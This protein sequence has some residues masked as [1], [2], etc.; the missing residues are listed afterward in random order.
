MAKAEK[1]L[2]RTGKA[3]VLVADDH[4]LF[5]SAL[6][7]V[8]AQVFGE[9]EL[10]EA[11]DLDEAIE[12]AT[13]TDDLDLILLDLNMPAM[14]GFC[15]LMSLR[16]EVPTVPVVVVSGSEDPDN[17]REAITY[18]AV[19]FIPK[20]LAMDAM[21]EALRTVLAG[22]V[23]VPAPADARPKATRRRSEEDER[24]AGRV[25][26]LSRQQR[27][28]LEMLVKGQS[29]KQIAYVLDVTES[30]VKAHVSAI[31]RKLNVQSRTQAVIH[32]GKLSLRDIGAAA[33]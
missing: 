28:V 31:L 16:N 2:T 20:S 3:R 24:F 21:A 4:P 14:N 6:H 7:Q 15:G 30:T 29:N 12:V 25:A 26:S 19:G 11:C 27:L 1:P 8:V 10:I 5:R 33:S 32:A 13:G 23:F 18:G 17:V 9:A 22:G